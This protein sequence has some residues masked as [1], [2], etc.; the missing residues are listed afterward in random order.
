M[1]RNPAEEF[2]D[3]DEAGVHSEAVLELA[4]EGVMARTGCRRGVLC[5]HQPI[6]RWEIA[7]WLVRVIDGDNPGRPP[8]SRFEDVI[9][10]RWWAGHVE[11]LAQL[12]ITLGCSTEPRLF[13]PNDPVTRGQMASFLGRAFELAEADP[14]GFD[15]VEN[16][17]HDA[18]IDALFAA[19]ITVGCG[20]D[21]LLYCPQG[22]T[23]RAEMASFLTRALEFQESG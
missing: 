20:T 4:S 19:G 5:P 1:E 9:V 16:T 11:R 7:V 21:P 8:R 12:R 3:L 17:G 18:D 10:G 23:T 15:D 6:R 13:C 2:S 14:A 22:P